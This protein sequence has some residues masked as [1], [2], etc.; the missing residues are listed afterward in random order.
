MVN[1]NIKGFT[2]IELLVVIAIIGV[3]AGLLLPALRSARERAKMISCISQLKQT[4]IAFVTYSTDYDDRYPAWRNLHSGSGGF[5]WYDVIQPYLGKDDGYWHGTT[6]EGRM[7]SCPAAPRNG[8][9]EY[10]DP[11]TG[12]KVQYRAS[13]PWKGVF[14][15]TEA[16]RFYQYNFIHWNSPDWPQ[17]SPELAKI[18]YSSE[19]IL[20]YCRWCPTD[21]IATPYLRRDTH[22]RGRPVL[23][24]DGHVK[25]HNEPEYLDYYVEQ[26]KP[27][28][29][30]DWSIPTDDLMIY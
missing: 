15:K 26:G 30:N 12:Q 24:M 2:L 14:S 3:L 25:T 16:K 7:L 19:S 18:K 5:G 6:N 29:K 23:Y 4:G 1:K 9:G 11:E 17:L 20:I 21:V 13:F 8:D 22:T 28:G 10:T 27:Y